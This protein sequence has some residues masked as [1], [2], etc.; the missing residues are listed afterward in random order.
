MQ[1]AIVEKREVAAA[2]LVV[3]DGTVTSQRLVAAPAANVAAM[4]VAVLVP[5]AAQM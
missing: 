3:A 1:T 2:V 4:L 5:A